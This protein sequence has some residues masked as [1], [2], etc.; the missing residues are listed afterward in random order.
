MGVGLLKLKAAAGRA[1]STCTRIGAGLPCEGDV[2]CVCRVVAGGHQ[3][4]S[5]QF[6]RRRPGRLSE[7]M[8]LA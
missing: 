6:A 8:V 3:G 1:Q 2:V 7:I 5:C 4:A